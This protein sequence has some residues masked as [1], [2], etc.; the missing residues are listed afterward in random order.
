[1]QCWLMEHVL[2]SPIGL[3]VAIHWADA[4]LFNLEVISVHPSQVDYID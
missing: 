1:M 3:S 2:I 4:R